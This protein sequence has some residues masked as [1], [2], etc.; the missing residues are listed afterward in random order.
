LDLAFIVDTSQSITDDNFDDIK[1]FMTDTISRMEISP[2][3]N[4]IAAISFGVTANVFLRF[5][6]I[7]GA[8][9][10]RPSLIAHFANFPRK[11]GITR[12]DLALLKAESDIFTAASGMRTAA[13]VRKVTIG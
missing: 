2:T 3:G 5:D 4:H 11:G 10:N 13:D 12:I 1:D 7:T 6:T 9:L 8:N